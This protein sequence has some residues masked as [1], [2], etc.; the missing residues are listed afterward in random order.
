MSPYRISTPPTVQ[1]GPRWGVTFKRKLYV[2]VARLFTDLRSKYRYQREY[3]QYLRDLADWKKKYG[4]GWY[5]ED[6][7]LTMERDKYFRYLHRVGI[8]MP[9]PPPIYINE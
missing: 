9:L 8:P 3:N 4:D 1:L 5:T 2:R 7:P 6:R